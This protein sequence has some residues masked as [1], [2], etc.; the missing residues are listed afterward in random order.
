MKRSYLSTTVLIIALALAG[1]S[2]KSNNMNEQQEQEGQQEM[3]ESSSMQEVTSMNSNYSA[4]LSGDNEVPDAAETDASGEAYF[5]VNSD[6]TEL[7]YT[8]TLTD[9][10]SVRMAHI[11]YG[12]SDA[13]G[14]IAVWLY[15]APDNKTPTMEPGPVNGT[16]KSGT[17]TDSGLNGPFEGKTVLD[18]IHAIQ[19]DSAYVQVHTAAYPAGELRGQIGM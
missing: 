18:L 15:P 16:L 3:T 8:V 19:H 12:T 2:K 1:C 6:S 10:D 13:N 7:N 5:Q 4:T 11:H 9:A 17:I 14:P